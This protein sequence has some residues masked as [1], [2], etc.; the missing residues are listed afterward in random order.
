MEKTIYL[1]T[2]GT[3]QE[4]IIQKIIFNRNIESYN[5]HLKGWAKFKD[6][7]PYLGIVEN[8]DDILKG[9]ALKINE[10]E[11]WIC[12]QWE[13]VPLY[14]KKIVD[15]YLENKQIV[16][17]YVYTKMADGPKTI[18]YDEYTLKKDDAQFIKDVNDFANSHQQH[19]EQNNMGFGDLIQLQQIQIKKDSPLLNQVLGVDNSYFSQIYQHC[20]QEMF[21]NEIQD[22]NNLLE[23]IA[24]KKIKFKK[25]DWIN[26]AYLVL[27]VIKNNHFIDKQIDFFYKQSQYYSGVMYLYVPNATCNVNNLIQ[28]IFSKQIKIIIDNN[29]T[30]LNEFYQKYQ[31]EL[32]NLP[33]FYIY[34]T[35]KINQKDLRGLT[36]FNN[37]TISTTIYDEQI[38][39]DLAIYES[40]KIFVFNNILLENPQ[41]MPHFYVDRMES[42][43]LTL[44]IVEMVLYKK[45]INNLI[46]RNEK[47]LNNYL[48]KIDIKPIRWTTSYYN[49][50]KYIY[51]SIYGYNLNLIEIFTKI[52]GDIFVYP[53]GVHLY[54]V[55]A[56]KLSL[57][58]IQI[59]Q[60]IK[61]NTL[62]KKHNKAS[63]LA[64]SNA[65]IH[66][67]VIKLSVSAISVF[68]SLK[69][70]FKDDLFIYI[71]YT[72]FGLVILFYA[73]KTL[74]E[75]YVII[76]KFKKN[77]DKNL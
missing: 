6:N 32:I 1:F 35:N 22:F 63:E 33:Y 50:A 69:L 17:G 19:N 41:K 61:I 55:I 68:A 28:D 31:I 51:D 15:I 47:I 5:A 71:G 52:N 56:N 67:A 21:K 30:N 53:A 3:F 65:K 27:K 7:S 45:L 64:Q 59:E 42:Q 25:G 13:D 72:I 75:R 74:F 4:E 11:L 16:Q 29:Q 23:Q 49:S 57:K 2:Y 12:E 62:V 36:M 26:T 20:T 60:N 39:E 18:I 24:I 76:K 34:T 10:K 44:F 54:K 77:F 70:F 14:T 40:A 37:K 48:N 9:K 43:F 38:T 58:E 73:I 8:K 46:D 66:G